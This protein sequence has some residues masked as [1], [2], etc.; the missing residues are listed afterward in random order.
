MFAQ[1]FRTEQALLFR[2]HRGKQNRPA[3]WQF[4]LGPGAR[5]FQQDAAAGGVI[6]GAVIDV[7]AFCVGHDAQVIVVGGIHHRFIFVVGDHAGTHGEHIA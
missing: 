4:I 5:E 6:D 7:V 1:V 3:G 2:G